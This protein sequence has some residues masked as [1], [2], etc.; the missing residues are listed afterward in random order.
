[1]PRQKA[2]V[3][4]IRGVHVSVDEL[5]DLFGVNKDSVTR[6]VRDDAMPKSSWGKYPAFECV[7]WYVERQATGGTQ[8]GQ[9]EEARKRLLEEQIKRAAMENDRE[10]G[11]L[12]DFEAVAT[13]LSSAF[14]AI[15]TQMRGLAPRNAARLATLD[16]PATIQRVLADEIRGVLTAAAGEVAAFAAVLADGGDSGSAPA[17]KRRAV[18]RRKPDIATGEPG[19]GAVAD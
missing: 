9:L 7:R 5:A 18:G 15:A 12:L 4:T 16:D 1:M 8:T 13:A 6:W 11:K 19:A 17:K 10:R 2:Q 3:G 14:A